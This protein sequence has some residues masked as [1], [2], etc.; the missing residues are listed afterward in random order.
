MHHTA[1]GGG[2][3]RTAR[4]TASTKHEWI[5]MKRET[6]V[7]GRKI[8]IRVG[9]N[10]FPPK[11]DCSVHKKSNQKRQKSLIF[12][13]RMTVDVPVM[14]PY[15]SQSFSGVGCVFRSLGSICPPVSWPTSSSP[16]CSA[17][18]YMSWA[19][20][21]QHWG[22]RHG[23]ITQSVTMTTRSVKSIQWLLRP[24]K[25]EVTN[26]SPCKWGLRVILFAFYLQYVTSYII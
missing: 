22:K 4:K 9:D 10:P 15:P 7:V 11:I 6:K 23:S 12:S 26:E 13:Q 14:S 17:E 21:W 16:C 20:L 25:W 24:N 8:S 5:N 2:K 1:S 19:T 18:L 3:C